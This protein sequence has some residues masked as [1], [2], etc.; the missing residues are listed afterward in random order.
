[1]LNTGLGA[2]PAAQQAVIR[3]DVQREIDAIGGAMQIA[4]Q[5]IGFDPSVPFTQQSY[6]NLSRVLAQNAALHELGVQ[7]H[8]LNGYTLARY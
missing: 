8:G 4:Q 1:F 3:E 7:G 2:L 5:T 6:V